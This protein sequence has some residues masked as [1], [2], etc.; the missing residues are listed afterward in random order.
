MEYIHPKKNQQLFEKSVREADEQEGTRSVT[1]CGI[2]TKYCDVWNVKYILHRNIEK[3]NLLGGAGWQG[4]HNSQKKGDV[5]MMGVLRER[6]F[7]RGSIHKLIQMCSW[8]KRLMRDRQIRLEKTHERAHNLSES[9]GMF[10]VQHCCV[11]NIG[12]L[13][14]LENGNVDHIVVPIDV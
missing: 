3:H 13:S 8:L 6:R 10:P 2:Q 5:Y 1:E 11:L 7:V 4:S 12:D 14:F 9:L